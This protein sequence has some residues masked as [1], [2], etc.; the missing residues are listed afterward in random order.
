M[1]S[2]NN[3]RKDILKMIIKDVIVFSNQI[4]QQIALESKP[5]NSYC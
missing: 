3:N 5:Q 1:N 4:F 2:F